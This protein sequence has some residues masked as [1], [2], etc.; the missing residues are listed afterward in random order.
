MGHEFG[1]KQVGNML[2]LP[3]VGEAEA[4]LFRDA[5]ERAER[6]KGLEDFREKLDREVPPEE[7]ATGGIDRVVKALH[8]R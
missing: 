7:V 4:A 1:G 2:I 6:P 5:G 8:D 3:P